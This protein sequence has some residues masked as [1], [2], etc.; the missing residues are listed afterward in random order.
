[1]LDKARHYYEAR[2]TYYSIVLIVNVIAMAALT[3]LGMNHLGVFLAGL[4]IYSFG[5]QKALVVELTAASA[6]SMNSSPVSRRTRIQH[7]A[8]L[9]FSIVY[10]VALVALTVMMQT[11]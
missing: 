6:N 10:T 4:A 3:S 1:M 7:T 9:W 11:N 5:L 2:T 8:V